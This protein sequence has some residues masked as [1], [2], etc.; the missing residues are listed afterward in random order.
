M[1]ECYIGAEGAKYLSE[2]LA[3]NEGLTSLKCAAS[4]PTP[5]VTSP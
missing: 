1:S 4:H 3:K 2:G 5:D